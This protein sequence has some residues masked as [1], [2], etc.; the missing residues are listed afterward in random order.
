MEWRKKRWHGHFE[1]DF[2]VM[3]GERMVT[4]KATI[5]R[6]CLPS[7][8]RHTHTHTYV[9]VSNFNDN[10]RIQDKNPFAHYSHQPC[11]LFLFSMLLKS[12]VVH[13]TIDY[14]YIYFIGA[15]CVGAISHAHQ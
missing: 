14:Y 4:G 11:P 5:A 10:D 9:N 3:S 13:F 2:G 15:F 6:L 7:T 8:Y 1:G 12:I